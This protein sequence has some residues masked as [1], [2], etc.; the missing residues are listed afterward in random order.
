MEQ[1]SFGYWLRLKR[2]ALDL[3]REEL[4]KQVGYSAATIRKIEDEERH[5]SAQVVE[6]LA[7]FF[8]ID[9]DE[10]TNFLRFARGDLQ[11]ALGEIKEDTPWHNPAKSARSNLPAIV[12]SLIG[13]KQEIADVREYLSKN[14]IR[15]VTLIGPPG[16]GKTRLG[17]ETARAS[18]SDFSDGVFFVSL[19]A[20]DDPD[21]IAPTLAQ[22]L[23]YVGA[24][25]ISTSDQIKEGI[26]DK[27][28]LF[29]IDNCEHLIEDVSLLVSELLSTCSDLKILATSRE[30][31]RIPGEWLY[32]V[33]A[34]DVPAFDEPHESSSIDIA[35]ISDFPALALFAERARAVRPDFALNSE[36]IQTV[37]MICA[38]LDGLPLAIELIAA[39]M[40]L[41]SPE[42]LLTR[43]NNQYVLSADGMRVVSAR[44][45]TLQDAID[46]S[47]SLLSHTEQKL[48]AYLS[49]FSGGFTLQAAEA[50]FSQSVVDKSVS[51][52]VTSLLDKSL[53]QF[54]SAESGDA[55]YTMLV[56][57]QEFARLRLRQMGEETEIR[58]QHLAYFLDLAERADQELRGPNQLEWLHRLESVRDNLRAALTWAIETGQ[59]KVGLHLARKLHWFWFVRGDHTEG[60]QWLGRVLALTNVSMYPEAQAEA[61]T[62]ISHHTWVQSGTEEAKSYIEQTLVIA[63]ERNDQ[64]NI[65][66]ALAHRGVALI[67]EGNFTA[68]RTTLEQSKALFQ[69]VRD[70]WGYAHAVIVLALGAFRQ[71]DQVTALALHEQ[72][73]TLF[74]ELGEKYFEA[75]ALRFIGILKG[76]QG[77]VRGGIAAL[78]ESLILAQKLDSKFEISVMLAWI[79]EVAQRIGKHAR[80]VHLYWAGKNVATSIG[81]WSQE[82][83]INFEND[84]APCR[85][86]LGESEFAEAVEQG[87]AMTMEQAIAYALE[88]SL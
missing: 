40:R 71:N 57:I 28:I 79:G 81:V 44:Q 72:A 32:P 82:D 34:L 74:R 47:Y 17:I 62:Q 60:R 53:L 87:R 18:L 66:R 5:P 21:L 15:L 65:A 45:K 68:A 13:R 36:N 35:T 86:A 31:L 10:R 63:Q 7:E 12:T 83:E 88:N 85:A 76:R 3:T 67:F 58:N 22:A 38:R 26:G 84:L 24:R 73:L 25:N 69:E 2:K 30:Y 52:L 27:Q 37:S 49:V 54:D 42:V 64:H 14:D 50:I 8:N 33:P 48:F 80:A 39:R 23:G 77:D 59:A 20:L 6:R 61:L 9:H 70:E 56:T 29:V 16:I 43:M 51:E 1:H 55:R 4:A 41:M 11:A 46:W 75:V 19:A 78:Q